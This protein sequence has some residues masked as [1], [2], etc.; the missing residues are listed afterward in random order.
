MEL[1]GEGNDIA[2]L[3]TTIDKELEV[4]DERVFLAEAE[5]KKGFGAHSD[6]HEV[7]TVGWPVLEGFESEVQFRKQVHLHNTSTNK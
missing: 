4:A 3:A 2:V 7:V 1:S 5:S 6:V